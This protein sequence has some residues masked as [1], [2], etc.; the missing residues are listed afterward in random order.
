MIIG[1]DPDIDRCGVF[2]VDSQPLFALRNLYLWQIF[3]LL[4][5]YRS[6]NLRP[7]V[8]IEAGWK[9][10]KGLSFTQNRKRSVDVGR[11]HAIGQLIEAFCKEFY[12]EHE[13][14]VPSKRTP[15]WDHATLIRLTGMDIKKSN[16][17]TR[18]AVRAVYFSTK[19][20][21]VFK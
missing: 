4:S 11:N 8:V 18:A 15:V 20:R 17:E 9:N 6:A 2:E 5:F 7:Y 19:G 10:K 12:I 3:D 21:E 13:L 1:I 14:F 16:Q